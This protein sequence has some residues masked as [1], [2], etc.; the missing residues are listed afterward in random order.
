LI[1][2]NPPRTLLTWRDLERGR[3][4]TRH[5]PKTALA[6]PVRSLHRNRSRLRERRPGHLDGDR[7][8]GASPFHASVRCLPVENHGEA[9]RMIGPS[10]KS[11]ERLCVEC[12]DS[13]TTK[14]S[15]FCSV[16][17]KWFCKECYSKRHVF[18]CQEE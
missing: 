13:C 15:V 17:M 2:R 11:H 16:C 10:T 3:E 14:R 5:S 1:F 18:E 4:N 12:H 6:W 8:G 7:S 9:A